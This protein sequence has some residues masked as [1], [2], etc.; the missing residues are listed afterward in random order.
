MWRKPEGREDCKARNIV[1]ESRCLVCNPATSPEEDDHVRDQPSGSTYTPREGI[2]IGESSRSLHERALE[3]VK[4]AEAFS[5]KS[6]IVKHWM[7]SHASLSSPPEMAFSISA[8]FKDCLSKQ[9]GEAF[10]INLSKDVLL[11]SKGEYVKIN[12]SK[13]VLLNSKGEYLKTSWG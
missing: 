9:I 7:N 1:Y 2:Y 5:A 12:F 13:D 4:D 11:N 3:H 6:H 8:R 10:K